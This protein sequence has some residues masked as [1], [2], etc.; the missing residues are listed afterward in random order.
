MSICG[1]LSLLLCG[2]IHVLATYDVVCTVVVVY[3]H[4]SGSTC[5][6]VVGV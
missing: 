2:W 1:P 4:V 3:S 5:D 6:Y